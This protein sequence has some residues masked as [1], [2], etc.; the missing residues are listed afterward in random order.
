MPT[1]WFKINNFGHLLMRNTQSTNRWNM[2]IRNSG[3]FS[4]STFSG[5]TY[6]NGIMPS[7]YNLV[8][9]LPSGNVGIGKNKCLRN[10]I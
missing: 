1:G 2:S 9:I 4:I 8:S 6:D 10:I 7:Q 3:L 5:G